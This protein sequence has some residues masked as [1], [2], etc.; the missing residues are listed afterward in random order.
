MK[1]TIPLENLVLVLPSGETTNK[2][3]TPPK[4]CKQANAKGSLSKFDTLEG[5][6]SAG[7]L[8]GARFAKVLRGR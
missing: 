7:K 6:R 4:P 8:A 3:V 1:K 5:Y 2:E